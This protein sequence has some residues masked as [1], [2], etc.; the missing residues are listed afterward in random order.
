MSE[1]LADQIREEFRKEYELSDVKTEI[2]NIIAEQLR[3]GFHSVV[4]AFDGYA[5]KV[6]KKS[7]CGDWYEIPEKFRIPVMDYIHSEGF[8]TKPGPLHCLNYE[9]YL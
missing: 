6:E 5:K 3:K 9:V 2:I 1:R 7:Y 8:L 4:I